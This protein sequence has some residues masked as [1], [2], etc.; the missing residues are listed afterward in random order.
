MTIEASDFSLICIG[1]MIL[2]LGIMAPRALFHL[3]QVTVGAVAGDRPRVDRWLIAIAVSILLCTGLWLGTGLFNA[4][5]HTLLDRYD[6]VALS[7]LFFAAPS[8]L[9]IARAWFNSRHRE[10]GGLNHALVALAIL[11]LPASMAIPTAALMEAVAAPQDQAA[12]SDNPASGVANAQF[13]TDNEVANDPVDY[14]IAAYLQA[15]FSGSYTVAPPPGMVGLN[16]YRHIPVFTAFW[17]DE[18]TDVLSFEATDTFGAIVSRIT[19]V[20]ANWAFSLA[21]FLYKLLCGFALLAVSFDAFIAPFVTLVSRA[22]HHR[23]V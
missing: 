16:F 17:L 15:N 1:A 3:G 19:Y 20:R 5:A 18:T 10:A 9:Q 7:F 8:G 23:P 6:L 11:A 21:V 14:P 2:F 12:A 13:F 4:K 22:R